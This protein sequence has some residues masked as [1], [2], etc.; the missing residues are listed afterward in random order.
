MARHIPHKNPKKKIGDFMI[1][2]SCERREGGPAFSKNLATLIRWSVVSLLAQANLAGADEP[3]KPW[4]QITDNFRITGEFRGRYEAYN[5][6]R[7]GPAVNNNNEYDFWALRGRLGALLTSQFADAYVQAEYSGTYGLPDDAFAVPGGA[8]GLGALYYT[9]NGRNTSPS[10]V[11]L[12]QAYVNLK[13]AALGLPGLSLKTGRF[14]VR[15]GLEYTT[16]DPKFN[17]LKTS[18]ISQRLVGT[19]D[20]AH[21]SRSFDGFAVA[22]DQPEFNVSLSA[23]HPTQGG[24]NL[25]AQDEISHIDLFYA[26][27]TSKKDALLPGTEGRLFY[28][29]YGDD[30]NT[31]VIDNRP[32]SRR[33]RLNRQDLQIHTVGTHVLT[34]QDWGPGTADGI[35]WGA[36]QFGDWTDLDHQA[37][38]F[39]VE[40][41]YQWTGLPL[42]PWLRGGYFL[43]SGDGD[44]GDGRHETFFQV[45]PT[46]RLYAKFPFFNLMNLQDAFAQLIVAP[47]QSTRLGIDFHHL[48]L[49]ETGDLFYAGAGASSRSGSFGFLGRPSTGRSTVGELVDV[50]FTHNLTKQLSWSAY[51]AHAFGGN[52][53][54]SFYRQK[55]DA[56]FAFVEFNLTF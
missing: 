50:S 24:F 22:Y 38:A 53:V 20:F 46:V 23:T 49:A 28:L 3:Q 54:D 27:L 40:A 25:R 10:D 34:V 47:T 6:F 15:E 7:P 11:H 48:S 29:Y 1:K 41:G 16:S 55:K 21:A 2:S 45:L 19:F 56:D 51:Y 42:K 5:F 43:G 33:P 32:T 36:Y 37:W 39:D 17:L 35:V 26:A 52:Y 14:E 12:K 31:Q 13:L 9:E 8:L 44:A 4:G 18:R 30:R